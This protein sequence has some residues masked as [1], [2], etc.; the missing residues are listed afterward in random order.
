MKAD[1]IKATGA[2][3]VQVQHAVPASAGLTEQQRREVEAIARQI[4]KQ[5]VEAALLKAKAVRG[6]R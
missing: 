4:A 2:P 3:D 6:G 1:E 5:E